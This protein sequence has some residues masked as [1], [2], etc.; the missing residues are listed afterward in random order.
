V[1]FGAST[2][3]QDRVGR[4]LNWAPYQHITRQMVEKALGQFRGKFMQLPP[5]YSALKMNGKPLYEYA[6]EG[7]E[8]P[9]EI[10]KRPVEVTELELLEW[11]EGGT[12]DHKWPTEEADKVEKDVA[13]KVWLQEK[14]ADGN[15]VDSAES[16]LAAKKRKLEENQD[17]LVS[18]RP[19]SK[20]MTSTTEEEATMSGGLQPPDIEK[21][22]EE[23]KKEINQELKDAGPPAARIRMTVTSGFYVRS[24][25]HD[26]GEAVGSQAMMAELIR[27]RQGQFELGKNVLEYSDLE[28]GEG[29]WGKKIEV[30]LDAWQ[31]GETL[32]SIPSFETG[33]VTN[34]EKSEAEEAELKAEAEEVEERDDKKISA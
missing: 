1:L 15:T 7:K 30:M 4:I 21:S 32:E 31:A 6:R 28:K 33:A 16:N 10:E 26:L 11:M 19:A 18:E 2:D 34:D 23:I 13:E 29:V 24:L 27:T 5:L 9:R 14:E 3:T 8:V 25:C 17:E 22:P 20:R 12:H